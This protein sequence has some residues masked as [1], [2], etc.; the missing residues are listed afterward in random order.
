MARSSGRA[1]RQVVSQ[2]VC[3]AVPLAVSQ[4]VHLTCQQNRVASD[5]CGPPA[6]PPVP[7]SAEDGHAANRFWQF[8]LGKVKVKV[9]QLQLDWQT[10]TAS[11]LL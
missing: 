3:V 9:T 11:E 5:L 4:S 8:R 6:L 10:A 7:L 1:G 2:A